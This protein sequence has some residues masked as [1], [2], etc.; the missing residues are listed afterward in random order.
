MRLWLKGG[1]PVFVPDAIQQ[2]GA[3][4]PDLP[5]PAMGSLLDAMQMAD[6]TGCL[7]LPLQVEDRP[8]GLALIWSSSLQAED[9]AHLSIF[10]GQV[11]AALEMARLHEELQ[12]H[13]RGEQAALLRLSQ[14]LLQAE[15]E[16]AV[17][18]RAL[19][20]AEEVLKPDA[21]EFLQLDGMQSWRRMAARTEEKV[22]AGEADRVPRSTFHVSRFTPQVAAAIKQAANRRETVVVPG[23][24][25][26]P[27]RL[28]P[29]RSWSRIGHLA[30]WFYI[31]AGPTRWTKVRIGWLR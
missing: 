1:Q 7:I 11:A 24:E 27:A 22:E 3:M 12:A 20:V 25:D 8:I 16:Q 23:D 26:A 18:A 30:C 9:A 21:I 13:H 4:I 2:V 14:G 29:A 31:G 6:D 19:Q 5:A 15:D 28:S 10:G 17:F